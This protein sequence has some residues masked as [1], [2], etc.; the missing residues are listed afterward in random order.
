M[1]ETKNW[2]GDP[3]YDKAYDEVAGGDGPERT[4]TLLNPATGE[5]EEPLSDDDKT[6][7]GKRTENRH[8]N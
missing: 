2:Y 1:T 7:G 8:N 5:E 3:K 4:V 6:P